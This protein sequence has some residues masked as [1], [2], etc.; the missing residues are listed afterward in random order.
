MP[1]VA[2]MGVGVKLTTLLVWPVLALL[3]WRR[4]RPSAVVAVAGAA[5]GFVA[6]GMWGYVLN[7]IHT[8]HVLGHG[9]SRLEVTSQ[10][11]FPGSLR[12]AVHVVYRMLDVSVLSNTLVYS[13]AAT[14]VVVGAAVGAQTYRRAGF[15]RA[16]LKGPCVATPLL[17]PALVIAAGAVIAFLTRIAHIPVHD[18]TLFG[19]LNRDAHEDYSAFG[20]LGAV[21]LLA[22]PVLTVGAY[23]A[24]KVDLRH[25]ALALAL[26]VFLVLLVLQAKYNP[27]LTRFLL[28][29][30]ALTAPLFGPLLPRPHRKRDPRRRRLAGG[31][32]HPRGQ[33]D[34]AASQPVW[35]TLAADPGPGGRAELAAGGG[36]GARPVPEAGACPR[37]RRSRRRPG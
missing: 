5:V 24:G 11:S 4:G 15:R 16:L 36:R 25:L 7:L 31:R 6:V 13:L 22:V 33:P 17:A 23:R 26:P 35:P 32:A 28:V 8:G 2:G 12:T 29:P 1:G 18:A 10:P 34:E 3:L 21:L 37:L 9:A 30:A 19:G 27:F 20:P 14:G